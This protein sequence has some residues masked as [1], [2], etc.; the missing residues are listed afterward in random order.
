[1]SNKKS[2]E[3]KKLSYELQA[4]AA[5]VHD[6]SQNCQGDAMALL[7]LLRELEKLHREIR[8]EAFQKSLPDNRQALYLLLRNIESLGG[9]PYI[10]RMRI[11]AFLANL[12]EEATKEEE[13]GER[14]MKN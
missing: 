9:W 12:P 4:I 5:A 8:D 1:M 6:A 14:E 2:V 11:Q 13:V 10:E 3:S 7:A